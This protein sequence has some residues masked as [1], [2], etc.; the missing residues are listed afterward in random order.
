MYCGI[1]NFIAQHTIT[2]LLVFS[3]QLLPHINMQ[4]LVTGISEIWTVIGT[5][6]RGSTVIT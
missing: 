2:K 5:D 4:F 1:R 3:S 6:E